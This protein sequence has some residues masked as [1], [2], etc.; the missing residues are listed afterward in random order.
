MDIII[1]L[2]LPHH[3]TATEWFISHTELQEPE[4][5]GRLCQVTRVFQWEATKDTVLHVALTAV[6][7]VHWRYTMEDRLNLLRLCQE[8]CNATTLTLPTDNGIV[9]KSLHGEQLAIQDG[10]HLGEG[11]RGGDGDIVYLRL[12]TMWY[13]IVLVYTM[14]HYA[15]IYTN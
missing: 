10:Q 11:N 12:C 13:T 15:S 6:L 8:A 9:A 5:A 1:S 4:Q 2:I 14:N 3:P 7:A